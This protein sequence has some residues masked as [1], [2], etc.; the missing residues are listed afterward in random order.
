MKIFKHRQQLYG[1]RMGASIMVNET[2]A[3]VNG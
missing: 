2:D 1:I 3:L